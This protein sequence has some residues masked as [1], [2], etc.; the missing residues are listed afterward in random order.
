MRI[1]KKI[2]ALGLA[3]LLAFT[4]A[5]C[6]AP[7]G[8]E[9]ENAAGAE[10]AGAAADSGSAALPADA[11]STAQGDASGAVE[12]NGDVMILFTSDI[13]CGV[14][15]GFGLAGLQQVRDT[16]EA[17]GYETILVDDGDAIQGEPLGTLTRGEAVI[18]LMNAAG[19]DVAIP[20]NHEF[21]YGMDRFLE[22]AEQADFPYIS[23]NL[24][25]EGEFLFEPYT[26][27]EAA[28][29]K[30]AFVGVTT[31]ESL[32]TS[33]PANFQNEEG[34]YIYGF[35]EDAT[36]EALY[37]AVQQAVDAARA[38][39]ADYVYVMGHLGMD[40]GA[41]PWTYADVLE[42]TTG[43]DV[44]LDGHSHDTD[45]IVMTDAGG[46]EVVRSACGTKL[47]CIGYSHISAEDG[48]VETN[49]WSW[50]NGIG[51]QEL[52]GI[53]NEMSA[54]VGAAVDDVNALLDEVVAQSQVTLTINDPEEVDSSGNPIRMVRRA[55]TNLGD[56]CA[57]AIRVVSGAD[58]GVENGGGIRKNLERG[59]VTYGDILSV[60]PFGNELCVIEVTGQQILDALEW[61]VH[62]LPDES[63]GFLQVSGLSYEVDAT[64]PSGCTADEHGMMT[65]IEGARR[66][67]HVLVGDEPLDP[68]GTYTLAGT[69][70]VLIEQGDGYT[71]F[72]GARVLQEGIALDNQV[73]IEYI[74]DTLGGEI[75][76]AY[77]DPYG[78]G[79]ITVQGAE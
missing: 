7:A 40:A 3:A 53:E 71:A 61:G 63:G 38:E 47:N 77:A 4:G 18:D 72:D 10:S 48:V 62:E 11:E 52:L 45:Q 73:L 69:N 8:G 65:G 32:A 56:F 55:E 66:V 76:G 24:N 34:E 67:S 37:E 17:Q 74:T 57:D 22:L 9:Q 26:I 51:A 19:Y 16:L 58:I 70:Y 1:W 27:V 14:D 15:Q 39:G 50:P 21:D 13:H 2:A 78:E 59:E 44:L 5:A 35:L 36:G 29:M 60:F 33:M 46:N 79:R 23:C 42:H 41:A 12:P 6:G 25:R 54:A 30:I 68:A 43:I 28:G 49:I 75:G 64:I 31:P 20:G